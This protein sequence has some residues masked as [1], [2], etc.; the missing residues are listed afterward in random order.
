MPQRTAA[1]MLDLNV[2]VGKASTVTVSQPVTC[3]ES[4]QSNDHN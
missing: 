2:S 4:K 3:S 1:E